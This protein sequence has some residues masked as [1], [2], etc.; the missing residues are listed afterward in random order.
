M[1][2]KIP[3][4]GNILMIGYGSVGRC[5]M[6][7]IEKHF[8]MPLSR[9]TVVDGH[10][11]RADAK[12][13]IDKGMNYLVQPIV[14]REPGTRRLGKYC[15]KGDLILNLS[16]EV[17]SLAIVDWCQKN[18]VLYLDTCIEPWANYYDNPRSRKSERTNYYLRHS[19]L[20][21]AQEVPEERP[22]GAGDP[23]RQSRPDH[24]FHQAGGARRR[25][26][27]P[28]RR[29]QADDARRLGQADAED[30]HQ[31]HPRR[32]ARPAGDERAEAAGRVLQHLVDPRLRR[33]GLPAGG[34]GLGH[35]REAP[36]GERRAST[37]SAAR[38]RSICASRAASPRCGPGRRSAGR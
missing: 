10:D 13:F 30:R 7:L 23:R 29:R 35:P 11:H 8:D 27:Q 14:R 4:S 21:A 38:R 17:S 9:V 16:V 25:E 2:Q 12:R 5:T 28:A 15:K 26:V 33:R 24:P 6:P 37:R 34:T 19:A 31:G 3:F 20:E 1:A 36:A 18:G 22:V 32:R